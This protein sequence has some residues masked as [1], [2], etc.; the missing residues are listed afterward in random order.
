MPHLFQFTGEHRDEGLGLQNEMEAF[1]MELKEGIEEIWTRSAGEP[2]VVDD[3]ASRMAEV[4]RKKAV[5]PV[6][7]VA[8]PD[9]AAGKDWRLK[10][11]DV[12]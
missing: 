5:N 10:L 12:K 1:E 2:S 9:T 8:K 7:K 11:F 4:E 3:W 6:D